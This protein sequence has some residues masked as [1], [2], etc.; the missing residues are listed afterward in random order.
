[1]CN[2]MKNYF[3]KSNFFKIFNKK[4]MPL[5][6]SLEELTSKNLIL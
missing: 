2:F 1:M 4:E 6:S 3:L 5:S